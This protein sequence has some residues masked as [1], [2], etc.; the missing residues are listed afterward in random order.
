MKGLIS[1]GLDKKI[2]YSIMIE[3]H[4]FLWSAQKIPN[5]NWENVVYICAYFNIEGET[6]KQNNFLVY[7]FQV[8]M[9]VGQS[10]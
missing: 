7:S 6:K 2:L 4:F 10:T 8:L 1:N 9:I 5:C 3:V